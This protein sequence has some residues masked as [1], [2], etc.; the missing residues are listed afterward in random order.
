MMKLE[1]AFEAYKKSFKDDFPTIPLASSM[2]D[3]E[4]IKTIDECIANNKDV[5]EMGILEL[6][7]VLY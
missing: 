5:Y 3:D 2:T 4:I 1:E 7:D 6:D